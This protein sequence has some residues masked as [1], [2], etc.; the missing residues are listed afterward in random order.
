VSGALVGRRVIVTHS[1]DAADD[2]RGTLSRAAELLV[3]LGASVVERAAI[4]IVPP[5]DP[6][7]LDD[8]LRRL[9]DYDWVVFTS[10]HAVDAVALRVRTFPPSTRRMAIGPQTLAAIERSGLG[11]A[12]TPPRAIAAAIPDALGDVRGR[13]ILLP[14]SDI[15]RPE[16]PAVLRE[17]GAIVDEVIA[18][19]T[20]AGA[21]AEA[22]VS[23]LVLGDADAV[24]FSSGSAVLAVVSAGGGRLPEVWRTRTR[25]RVVCIGPVTAAAAAAADLPVDAVAEQHDS[26]GLVSAVTRALTD[27]FLD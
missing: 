15:A 13:R 17:H 16:L 9:E 12:A 25:P 22:I 18:Y 27:P 3:A 20:I 26:A 11:P 2:V 19:R 7:P 14:R 21:G 4:E 1:R 5:A 6:A 24:T 10:R 23:A 8:A